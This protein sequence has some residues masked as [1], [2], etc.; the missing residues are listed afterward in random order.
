MYSLQKYIGGTAVC[1]KILM[2][3]TKG[4]AQLTSNYTYFSDSCI[5]G[6]KTAEEAMAE[7][8]D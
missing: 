4:C 5:S 2:M 7:V 6:M 8:V 1:M 3:A